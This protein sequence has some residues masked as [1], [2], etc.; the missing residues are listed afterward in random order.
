[1]IG[2]CGA[3]ALAGA[4]QWRPPAPPAFARD[5][6]AAGLAA[7]AAALPAELPPDGLAR[8]VRSSPDG[9]PLTPALAAARAVQPLCAA[10]AGQRGD[11]EVDPS[12]MVALLGLGPGLTPSGDDFLGGVMVALALAGRT[13]GRNALWRALAPRTG[14]LTTAISAAHLA[15]AA[16]G[17]GSAAL[18]ALLNAVLA[19]DAAALPPALAAVAAIGHTSGWDALAGALT[20]LRAL[21]DAPVVNRAAS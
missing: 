5:R 1:R 6:L 16:Q 14:A 9:R 3:V 18:H 17:Q 10:L 12:G 19:N 20:V 8:L 11:G 21:A 2:E 7:C 4:P 13:G 15:A